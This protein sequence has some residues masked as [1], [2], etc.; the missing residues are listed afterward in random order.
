[1]RYH[2]S[3]V[4]GKEWF[5]NDLQITLYDCIGRCKRL[6]TSF[7]DLFPHLKVANTVA[8]CCVRRLQVLIF[9]LQPL[10]G[11]IGGILD[12]KMS[13]KNKLKIFDLLSSSILP[14]F[15][16]YIL[17]REFLSSEH[18]GIVFAGELVQ[19]LLQEGGLILEILDLLRISILVSSQ[20]CVLCSEL[21]SVKYNGVVF[22][23]T[24]L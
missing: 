6:A 16:R 18:T 8:M 11:S 3:S 14:L 20:D 12:G 24:P 7:Q 17:R 2:Y 10:D 4:I 5:S 15:Q 21:L 9:L 13:I 22:A 19:G 23:S 1:M